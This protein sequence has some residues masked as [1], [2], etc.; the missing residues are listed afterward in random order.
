MFLGSVLLLASL[1][2]QAEPLSL[3]S[4]AKAVQTGSQ[5]G[6]Q[7]YA[8]MPVK[9]IPNARPLNWN[10]SS[11]SLALAGIVG[12]PNRRGA[13][14]TLQTGGR[15]PTALDRRLLRY[16]MDTD[17][18]DEVFNANPGFSLR[19]VKWLGQTADL[20]FGL[21]N[22]A[23]KQVGV[24]V[25]R[26]GQEPRVVNVGEGVSL[27]TIAT[28]SELPVLVVC[29]SGSERSSVTAYSLD[30]TAEVKKV[31]E[32]LIAA[33]L[34]ESENPNFAVLVG[35]NPASGRGTETFGIDLRTASIVPESAIPAET[36]FTQKPVFDFVLRSAPIAGVP[37]EK[38]DVFA[39]KVGV[40]P[41]FLCRN[42]RSQV[43]SPDGLKTAVWDGSSVFIYEFV[44]VKPK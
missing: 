20:A 19:Q 7:S 36:P 22:V 34:R 10:R 41:V 26:R 5:A 32:G 13:R 14:Q 42:A 33:T 4:G 21:E 11:Q 40:S 6:S 9:V 39:Q 3:K 43:T 31:P 2:S 18:T 16:N 17:T 38:S 30:Q 44:P 15:L 29:Q 27:I 24:V 23:G 28:S 8:L 37:G 35:V 12:F 1:S 25:S